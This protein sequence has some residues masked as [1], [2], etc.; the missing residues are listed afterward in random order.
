M[1]CWVGALEKPMS[2]EATKRGGERKGEIGYK[3]DNTSCGRQKNV[4][5][6]NV[7]FLTIFAS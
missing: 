1:G 6:I 7:V 5:G 3:D 4:K 2:K